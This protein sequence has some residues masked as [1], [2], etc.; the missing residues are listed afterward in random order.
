[1]SMRSSSI[2]TLQRSATSRV[3]ATASG[4]SRKSRPH[5]LL[6][7]E[8][9]LL[10][11]EAQTVLLRETRP[12]LDAEQHVVS[13]RVCLRQV[14]HVVGGHQLEAGALRE[15]GHARVHLGQLA[16]ARLLH[17]QVDVLPAEDLAEPL[18]LGLGG[19]GLPVLQR[20]RQPAARAAA[21][22]DEPLRV[23]RQAPSSPCAACSSSPPGRP[24]CPA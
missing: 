5:L 11:G 14:V 23:L 17:L 16:D 24:G 9:E 22:A 8:E 20:L 21:Q 13:G 4:W 1:M 10:R 6:A 15:L 19:R 12:G 2:S 18:H 3:L 7:L